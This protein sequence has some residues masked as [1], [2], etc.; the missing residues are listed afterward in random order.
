LTYKRFTIVL[1]RSL[2]SDHVTIC[3]LNNWWFDTT[4]GPPTPHTGYSG[5]PGQ[6]TSKY[7]YTSKKPRQNQP[8]MSRDHLISSDLYTCEAIR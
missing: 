5:D 8:P 3:A 7:K 1:A 4:V 6:D 2:F